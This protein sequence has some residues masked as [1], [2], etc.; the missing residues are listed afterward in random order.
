M[1]V[2]H[3]NKFH[4]IRGGCE[5]VYFE[6]ANILESHGHKSLFFSMHHPDNVSCET[7]DYFMPYVD[8][9]T[10]GNSI[11]SQLKNAGRIL[12]SLDAR[13]RL[14][15]LLNKHHVDIAHL[16]NIYHQISPSILHTLAKK[17][18][19]VVM[20]LHDYKMACASYSMMV[21]GKPCEACSGGRY[22]EIIKN[23]CVKGSFVKSCLAALEMYVHHRVFEI[24]DNVDIFISPSLFLKHKLEDMGFK[25]EIVHL[26][27][28]IDTEKFK[29]V[30]SE[31]NDR[32]N[33]I[34]YFGRLSLEKG[35]YTLIKAAKLLKTNRKIEI[36]IIGDGPIRED[37]EEKVKSDGINSVRFLGYLKG[38]ALYKEV[39]K[40]LAVV[41]PSEWY[42]N[43]PMSV[44]EA[45][46][47][48]KP[49]I[50]A[51][52][53]GIPE[54][55]KDNITGLTFEPGNAEDLRNKIEYMITNKDTM[56]EMG[57]KARKMA[58]EEF[59][60]EKHYQKLIEIY[61]SAIG[62]YR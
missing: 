30:N 5:S 61:Q 19:P 10:N 58:E 20:T 9:N 59:N 41:L 54:L 22:F 36:K 13:K 44:L 18:I 40:C 43:N 27:N 35:L 48:G 46:A 53:G 62:K 17:K 6:T 3:I 2:L 45:F 55:V 15:K 4:Y 24:Y 31:E 26:P 49:V 50:G 25:K 38:E 29:K 16:H 11:L 1:N 51:S 23:K 37:L 28:F 57:K 8:L 32:E 56:V 39:K 60:A 42:E 34:I 14:S 52:I 7:N 21:H 12:Y 47:L 33:A